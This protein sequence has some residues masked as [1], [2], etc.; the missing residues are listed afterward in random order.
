MPGHP[1]AVEN[2][3]VIGKNN[4]RKK[5]RS[6]DSK[7]E[8]IKALT[9]VLVIPLIICINM[10]S[11]RKKKRSIY[12]K[13]EKTIMFQKLIITSSLRENDIHKDLS[14]NTLAYD[15][16]IQDLTSPCW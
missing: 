3:P 16:I 12:T 11:E 10:K 6:I 15:I 5:K 14:P 1:I 4:E 2:N 8:I 7:K 9:P 13:K